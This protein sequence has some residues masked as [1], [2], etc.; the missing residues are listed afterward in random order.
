MNRGVTCIMVT[1]HLPERRPLALLA[2]ES[3]KQQTYEDRFLVIVNQS[4]DKVQPFNI[5]HPLI[6]EVLCETGRKTL[7]DLLNIG[8]DNAN[9][10]FMAIFDDDDWSR[11]DR[12]S[13]QMSFMNDNVDFVALDW[14]A[15]YDWC[16]QKS[17]VRYF[18]G[19]GSLYRLNGQRYT[20]Q[21]KYVDKVFDEKFSRQIRL[22]NDP[23][24]YVRGC[25]VSNVCGRSHLLRG[26]EPIEHSA[27]IEKML[28][29][30]EA[31]Q[32][33]SKQPLTPVTLPIE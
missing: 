26:T 12:L 1:G 24:V 31:M 19:G 10:P 33:S 14:S 2:I 16:T 6:R 20:P 5:S 29:T 3:F 21:T 30:F 28:K 18:V 8:L 23:E 11:A 9:T 25:H 27:E 15:C 13:Y 4:P 22:N 7:G 17:Y 32:I